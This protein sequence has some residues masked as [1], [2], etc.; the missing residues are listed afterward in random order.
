[1][2]VTDANYFD[3]TGSVAVVTGGSGVLG[4]AMARGLAAAGARVAIVGRRQEAAQRVA[5]EI[6]D[7]GGEAMALP[8]DVLDAE[9]L[10]SARD[11]LLDK[12]GQIDVLVN[13]A[14]GNRAD[15]TVF[16]EL[17]LFDLTPEAFR[18]VV[19]LNLTGTLLPSQIFGK[20]MAERQS[21]SIINISS[22]AAQKP[23]TRVAGYSAA[24]AAVDNLTR[25]LAVHIAQ[26]YGAGVRVNAMAPGFFVAD[27][28]RALLL[29][30][31]GSLTD[32][33]RQIIDHTPMGRFGA[34]EDLIGTLLW[35]ASD[36]SSFVTGV[37][38]PVDGGYAAFGGV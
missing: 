28:N 32:R 12:W 2:T 17:T 15:A 36:A 19:D 5:T 29:N 1:M 13:G 34:P 24:K 30:E 9:A 3:L 7:A 4:S 25:W 8:A 11:G 27:Q 23:L 16:G 35:L 31:D 26:A 22:M 14:G 38:V 37:V 10:V 20:P 18:Q 6:T 21:G 33:G